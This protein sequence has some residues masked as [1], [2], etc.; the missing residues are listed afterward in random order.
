ML[1]SSLFCSTKHTSAEGENRGLFN[2]ST[3]FRQDDNYSLKNKLGANSEQTYTSRK[4]TMLRDAAVMSYKA[5]RDYLTESQATDYIEN[6]ASLNRLKPL[7]NTSDLPKLRT[8]GK[9]TQDL[10][11]RKIDK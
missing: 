2:L 11:T 9:M 4:D 3:D 5:Q 8:Q 1:E 6:I 7:Q 10:P